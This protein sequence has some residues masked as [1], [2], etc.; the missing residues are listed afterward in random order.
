MQPVGSGTGI[1]DH[2]VADIDAG[3]IAAWKAAGD[4]QSP[5]SRATANVEDMRTLGECKLLGIEAEMLAEHACLPG[6]ASHFCDVLS[7]NNVA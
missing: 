6:Q 7:I 1:R 5:F 3:D 2:E 4:L